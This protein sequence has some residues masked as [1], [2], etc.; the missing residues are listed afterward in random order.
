MS[1]GSEHGF[2]SLVDLKTGDIVWFNVIYVGAGELRDA[3]G[4]TTAVAQLFANMPER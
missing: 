3:K 1:T 4:A 2:A